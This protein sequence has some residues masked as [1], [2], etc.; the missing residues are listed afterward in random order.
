MLVWSLTYAPTI[1]LTNSLTFS[2]IK[3]AE[4]DYGPIRFFGS[5]GW[6]VAGWMLTAWRSTESLKIG[7]NDC[8][9]LA[10]G[11]AVLM[12]LFCFTLPDTP[13]A[14]SGVSP[15]AFAKAFALLLKPRIAVFLAVSFVGGMVLQFYF[16]PA[17][18]YLEYLKTDPNYISTV[19]SIGQIFEMAAM[20]SLPFFLKKYG[21][22]NVLFLGMMAFAIRNLVFA[23]GWP[24][25]LV[26]ASIGLHGIS[27]V[28]FFVVSFI[29]IDAVAPKDIRASAQ[30]L[31]TLIVFGF[32][33][34]LGNILEAKAEGWFTPPG[35]SLIWWKFFTLATVLSALCAV[36]FLLTFPKGSMKDAAGA[37]AEPAPAPAPAPAGTGTTS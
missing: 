14:K 20:L 15:F 33:N 25:W 13:P 35:G 30:G 19:L 28:F 11:A 6:I 17:G 12:G 22:R 24:Y 4:K 5:I 21:P 37:P 34:W 26:A 10:G 8:L 3:D 16:T 27:F 31:L 32:G 1:S 29:F 7:G 9:Y 2:H 36:V 18:T 23:I